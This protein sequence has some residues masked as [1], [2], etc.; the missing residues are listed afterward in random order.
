[1]FHLHYYHHQSKKVGKMK[2][3]KEFRAQMVPEWQEA[4]MDYDHLKTLLKAIQTFKQT[5]GPFP[6]PATRHSL[7][8][9]FS[10]LTQRSYSPLSTPTSDIESQSIV[11]KSVPRDGQDCYETTFLF[12]SEEGGEYEI[13]YFR[14]LDEEFNKV[15]NFYRSKVEEVMKEAAM[16]NKQMD[17]LIAFRIKVDNPQ[18]RFDGQVEL[19]RLA[20]DVSA[21]TAALSASTPSSAKPSGKGRFV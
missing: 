3:G 8:R 19:N 6:S 21:S 16:L 5:T 1:M 2:F 18:V 17:A 9:T 12:A 11:V 10:G 14:K 4:Y 13:A 20:S 7:Y 15:V